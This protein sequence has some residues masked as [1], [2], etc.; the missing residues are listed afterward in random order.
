MPLF[1][2][3]RLSHIPKHTCAAHRQKT[4]KT[5]PESLLP[6][7]AAGTEDGVATLIPPPCYR[8]DET[9]TRVLHPHTTFSGR[10]CCS[11]T[12]WPTRHSSFHP[13]A[14]H[15][16]KFRNVR[17]I[18]R[19]KRI[20]S[21]SSDVVAMEPP[22][23]PLEIFELIIDNIVG[24]EV[25]RTCALVCR[26]W[27]LHARRNIF[28]VVSLHENK[29][30]GVFEDEKGAA[31]LHLQWRRVRVA[32]LAS[33][34]Q[35]V[36]IAWEFSG[37]LVP[38]SFSFTRLKRLKLYSSDV[39]YCYPGAHEIR[40][41][42][43]LLHALPI[44]HLEISASYFATFRL[45]LSL[46]DTAYPSLKH[47]KI[48]LISIQDMHSRFRSVIIDQA[49]EIMRSYDTVHASEHTMLESLE[50]WENMPCASAIAVFLLHPNCPIR[51]SKLKTLK[52][53]SDP[54]TGHGL[55]SILVPIV[56]SSLPHLV[57]SCSDS[58]LCVDTQRSPALRRLTLTVALTA[59][60]LLRVAQI[61][62]NDL[63][64]L[65]HLILRIRQ[66][67]EAHEHFHRRACRVL[68]LCLA[69]CS[70]RQVDVES[71]MRAGDLKV[72][73]PLSAERSNIRM[74]SPPCIVIG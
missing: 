57:I 56:P 48:S 74:L 1:V 51:I 50:L 61:I 29:C 46:W 62:N 14:G 71:K 49:S 16:M 30:K 72:L 39:A 70:I 21:R 64:T 34:I 22:V 27:R 55:A 60:A 31:R 36:S 3:S 44:T 8:H 65:E 35:D 66:P 32:C 20:S 68:D 15:T 40:S 11:N 12:H 17:D 42:S 33:L 18:L 23:F 59:E 28:R 47:L 69:R 4:H 58:D 54:I 63:L 10:F 6:L 37:T 7:K 19:H 38:C 43:Q 24:V 45:F 73:L 5:A 9:R 2:A 67:W 25:L 13:P 26:S 53:H 52:L 41:A